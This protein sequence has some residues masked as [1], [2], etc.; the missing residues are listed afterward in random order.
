MSFEDLP[1]GWPS[2]S[3][4]DPNLAADVVDLCCSL[5]DRENNSLALLLCD[6]Q[7]RLVQPICLEQLPSAPDEGAARQLGRLLSE[8]PIHGTLV[9]AF[10]RPGAYLDDDTR[11]WHQAMIEAGR[12]ASVQLLG[13]YL[14]TP[15]RVV[16]LAGPGERAEIAV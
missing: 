9:A 12:M 1:T 16:R 4:I 10:G 13:C 3:L 7:G 6:E 15:Q 5:R 8:L 11:A 14:A 2:Q